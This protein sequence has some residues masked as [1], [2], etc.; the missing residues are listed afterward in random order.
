MTS[1][2]TPDIRPAVAEDSAAPQTAPRRPKAQKMEA[3]TAISY[4]GATLFALACL[5]PFWMVVAGS[6]TAETALSR[7]GYSFWPTPFS[8]DAYT[9]LFSGGR[10]WLAYGATLFITVVGTAIALAA[11]SGI[12][13]VIARGLPRLSTPLAIFAYIPMLFTGGLVP[14]Y[15]LVTQVLQLQNS[16][17]SVIF[18]LALAPFLV[19]VQVSFFR[20]VP[21]EILDSAKIDGAG[22]L[23]VFFQIVLPL[24]KPVLAVIALFYA[25][26]YWNDWFHALLFINDVNQYPLQ[27]VLQNLIASVANANNLSTTGAA[28]VYQIRLAMTVVTIAPILFAYPFAQRYFVKGLTLGATKG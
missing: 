4:V 28:P 17:F 13:W 25:V 14:L 20:A 6:F 12:A 9:T 10:I 27:L 15:I 21:A 7:S 16:L 11:T 24:S 26:T 3:F 23:R 5:I 19:F 8:L 2:L 22:E 1:V 18:P